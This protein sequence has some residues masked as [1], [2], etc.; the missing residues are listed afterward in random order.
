MKNNF[1]YQ[2]N[3]IILGSRDAIR[4]AFDK[5]LVEDGEGWMEMIMSRDQTSHTDNKHICGCDRR[6][7]PRTYFDLFES[8]ALRMSGL[9]G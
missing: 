5:G 1:V 6:A 7:H 2:G 4:E 9:V 8:L 3:S